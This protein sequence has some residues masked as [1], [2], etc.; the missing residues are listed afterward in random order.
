MLAYYFIRAMAYKDPD[1]LSKIQYP[2]QYT[3]LPLNNYYK[4]NGF[5]IDQGGFCKHDTPFL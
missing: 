5:T 1:A 2:S 4:L 3:K